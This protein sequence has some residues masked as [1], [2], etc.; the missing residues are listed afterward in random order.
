LGSSGGEAAVGED[1]DEGDGDVDAEVEGEVEEGEV[2]DELGFS[3]ELVVPG[4][5]CGELLS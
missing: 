3:P 4:F 5:C 2:E 1:E